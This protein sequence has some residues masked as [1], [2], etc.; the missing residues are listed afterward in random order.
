MVLSFRGT[1][2]AHVATV[3]QLKQYTTLCK[4]SLS[5]STF[6]FFFFMCYCRYTAGYRYGLTLHLV[7]SLA[8]IISYGPRT[9]GSWAADG[10]LVL[11]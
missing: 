4:G 3:Y 10:L 11:V 6:R 2:S 9:I 8:Y 1:L 5:E 7:V